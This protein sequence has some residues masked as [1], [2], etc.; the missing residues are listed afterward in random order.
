MAK[1]EFKIGEYAVGGIVEVLVEPNDNDSPGDEVTI[2]FCDFNTKKV[3]KD[4]SFQSRQ[5]GV[6]NKIQ[7]FLWDN[8][9]DY[10][11]DK[12]IEYINTQTVLN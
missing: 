10:Y 1:K 2:K 9:S 6:K 4:E 3:I 11:A 12:I 8:T 7:E 5:F